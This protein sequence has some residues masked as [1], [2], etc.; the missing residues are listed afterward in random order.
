MS[1]PAD[2][3]VSETLRTGLA[4]TVRAP[5]AWRSQ[6]KIERAVRA[7]DRESIYTG[8]SPTGRS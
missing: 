3:Y 5:Q 2:F 8:S 1:G 6:T 7:L 4:V